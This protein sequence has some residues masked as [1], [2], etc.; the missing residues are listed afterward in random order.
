MVAD[1]N[2]PRWATPEEMAELLAFCAGSDDEVGQGS[3]GN[4]LKS[5]VYDASTC[6]RSSRIRS[7][8]RSSRSAVTSNR[9]PTML[10]TTV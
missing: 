8:L 6:R 2:V 7:L 5:G 1:A 10:P 9:P 4:G 3:G